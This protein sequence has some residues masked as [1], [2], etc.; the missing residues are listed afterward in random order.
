MSTQYGILGQAYIGLTTYVV[1]NYGYGYG[2][3]YG[4]ESLTPVEDESLLPVSMYVVPS[5]KN[6]VITSIF[7]TNHDSNPINYDIAIVPNGESLSKKHHIR[8]D[9]PVVANGF[10]MFTSKISMSAGD[11]VVVLPSVAD[12]VGFTIFG[13]EI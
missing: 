4:Y 9:Y 12:K 5:G 7:I 6:A 1:P 13:L 10:D 3:G 2:Y 8:W 11:S